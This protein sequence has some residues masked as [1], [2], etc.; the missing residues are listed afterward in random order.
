M[1]H[2]SPPPSP[3][4][5]HQ[6]QKYPA[7]NPFNPL[8][9]ASSPK[10]LIQRASAFN[11]VLAS[12]SQKFN[13]RDFPL[14]YNPLLYS[15]ALLWPQFFFPSTSGISTPSTPATPRSP[16]YSSHRDYTLT[17]EKEEPIDEPDMPLNLSTKPL[18]GSNIDRNTSSS[19]SSLHEDHLRSTPPPSSPPGY[20][21]SALL[22]HP[23]THH[24]PNSTI[25]W[26]PA[27]MC[28]KEG[29]GSISGD[30]RAGGS[31]IGI[32]RDDPIVKKFKY[33]RRSSFHRAQHHHHQEL[34]EHERRLSIISG[35]STSQTPPSPVLT[36]IPS[37]APDVGQIYSRFH[38]QHSAQHLQHRTSREFDF[39]STSSVSTPQTKAAT[40]SGG[41]SANIGD[42]YN[43]ISNNNNSNKFSNNNS[44]NSSRNSSGCSVKSETESARPDSTA[45][46]VHGGDMV[47]TIRGCD[48]EE[49]RR[50][51][52]F[53]CKQCGKTF[54]RSST[55]S[56]HL[57]IHSDTRPYPCQYCGKR[58]HQKS[59]MKKHTY[60]HTD[61]N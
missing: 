10:Y 24:H 9:M 43:A 5:A 3:Q 16:G 42:F 61:D 40:E 30:E 7:L 52:S 54:K 25:I 59:D 51:R 50:E 58:F 29:K 35:H 44:N 2:L 34:L 21:S 56:T 11:T 19:S 12:A 39:F 28:E 6:Q 26:S 49:K 53:Q 48:S 18:S 37:G 47:T 32:T 31:H 41:G 14:L 22:G 4:S 55:L 38:Q 13:G 33:E 36:R 20:T 15:S 60:I 17:P 8:D 45:M 1:E 57:L 46:L 27:S 23:Q